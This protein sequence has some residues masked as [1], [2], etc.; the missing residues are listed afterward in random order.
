MADSS[1]CHLCPAQG[2]AESKKDDTEDDED[3]NK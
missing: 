3:N 1:L 2:P